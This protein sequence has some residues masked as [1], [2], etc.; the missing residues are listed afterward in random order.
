MK[1][2]LWAI[3]F[4]IFGQDEEDLTE[5]DLEAVMSFGGS[6]DTDPVPI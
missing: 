5:L 3:Y 2:L 4:K 6:D 1:H